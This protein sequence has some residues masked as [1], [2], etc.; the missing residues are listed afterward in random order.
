MAWQDWWTS[1]LKAQTHMYSSRFLGRAT[2]RRLGKMW[3]GSVYIFGNIFTFLSTC[4]FKTS[5]FGLF[6]RLCHTY[7][8]KSLESF[9]YNLLL[10]S[11]TFLWTLKMD[12]INS[13]LGFIK[14]FPLFLKRHPFQSVWAQC[15]TTPFIC[16]KSF[17]DDTSCFVPHFTFP[18]FSL[19]ST[20]PK[21]STNIRQKKSGGK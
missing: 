16:C 2:V 4:V 13:S 19:H 20:L 7:H 15:M 14:V 9:L 18:H 1:V 6:Q 8:C 10:R 21:S 11:Q 17:Q 3:N 12:L 5:L